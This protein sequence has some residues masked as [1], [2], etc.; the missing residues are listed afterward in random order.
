[1]RTKTEKGFTLIEMI[2]V[3]VIIS[4][5]AAVAIPMVETSVKRDKELE[6]RR[7]LRTIRTAIDEYKKFI[8]DNNIKMDE[9]TYNYPEELED[10]VKG[11]EYKDEKGEEKIKKFLRSLPIDPMTNS[12][13]WGMR[14]YQDKRDENS[15]GGEN[16]WD[17]FTKSERKALDGTYYKDW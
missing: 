15:W 12:D 6:L 17:V 13:E 11:I 8:E 9:D 5:L 3:V 2:I 4:V 10:L 16:V 1:M 7:S 14:S